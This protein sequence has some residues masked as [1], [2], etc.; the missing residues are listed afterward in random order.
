MA[1]LLG[2]RKSIWKSMILLITVGLDCLLNTTTFDNMAE[3]LVVPKEQAN[4]MVRV[5]PG[6]VW[7]PLS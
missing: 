5:P 1:L 7:H 3:L 6:K 2:P 4:E